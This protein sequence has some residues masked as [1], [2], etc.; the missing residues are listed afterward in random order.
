MRGY[1]PVTIF[2]PVKNGEATIKNCIDSLLEVDYPKKKIWVIDNMSTDKTP[3][4][5]KS[6]GKKIKWERMAGPVPR[7][8][9]YIL[10][11]VKTEFL[12]YTNA[13]CTVEKD[14]LKKLIK[15]FT[16]KE[17]VATAGYFATPEK[18]NRLQRLIGREME[19][20]FKRFP[21]YITRAPDANLCVR[22]DVAKEVGFDEKFFW[23]W[24]SDF[25]YRLT[26]RG[27]MKYIPDAYVYHYH[28][29]TWKGFFK[30]QMNNA[31]ATPLLFLKKKKE[32]VIGDH[33][34]TMEMGISLG[35]AYLGIL[36][37]LVGLFFTPLLKVALFFKILLL[38]IFSKNALKLSENIGDFFWLM[39]IF[40]IRTAAWVIGL[41]IGFFKLVGG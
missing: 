4:I 15:G 18:V 2:V 34:S 6:Y 3:E 41:P 16:S 7:L 26:K 5:L 30:Q 8:H 10:S 14:W 25:G 39:G 36:F 1:P 31:K 11:K 12:A 20:R 27:K 38:G 28:R 22:V 29:S 40:L 21:E 37:F 32:N 13:D 17:I 9:N 23:S 19:E 35:I 33:I 24:E